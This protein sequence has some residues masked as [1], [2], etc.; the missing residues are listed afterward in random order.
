MSIWEGF[1]EYYSQFGATGMLLLAKA[2]MNGRQQEALIDIPDF[3]HPVHLRFRTTD[4]PTFRQV[5]R[6]AE[7]D[8]EMARTPRV[9][10][11]AGAN[12]GLTSVFY[13]NK[14]PQA[15]IIAIEPEI[16]NFQVL[17]KNTNPYPNI[18]TLNAALWGRNGTINLIDPGVGQDGFVASDI[19]GFGGQTGKAVPAFTI[20]KIMSDFKLTYVDIL[21]IDIEGAEKE[22]FAD[23]S[24][25]IQKVGVIVIEFHDRMKSGCSRAVYSAVKDFEFEWHKEGTVFFLRKEYVVDP[26]LSQ[27]TVS[28]RTAL[29]RQNIKFRARAAQ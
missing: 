14:Y 23:P 12:I 5:I 19:G 9:I 27:Q 2:R 28:S 11:D 22:V 16:S 21:K 15:K 13:S 17:Q 8:W 26:S 29:D 24:A 25:W 7:Y 18:A 10:I 1:R 6:N 3:Q 4:V 20:D